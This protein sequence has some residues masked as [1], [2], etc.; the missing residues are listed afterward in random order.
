M[1]PRPRLV[2]A[3]PERVC[4]TPVV[5]GIMVSGARMLMF[6]PARPKSPPHGKEGRN[7]VADR[8]ALCDRRSQ[9]GVRGRDERGRLFGPVFFM[10]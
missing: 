3:R 1:T 5:S 6:G 9:A 7:K 2:G 4:A 8:I 10:S